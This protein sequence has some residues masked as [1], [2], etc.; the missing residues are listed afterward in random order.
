VLSCDL[1]NLIYD[2]YIYE[3]CNLLLGVL[4]C[5]ACQS[6][7]R[8]SSNGLFPTLLLLGHLA[9]HSLPHSDIE[10]GCEARA[11]TDLSAVLVEDEGR[12]CDEESDTA[13]EGASPV[14][15]ETG[16]HL[17]GEL[18]ASEVS[19][20]SYVKV[21]E[22]GVRGGKPLRRQSEGWC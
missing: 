20:S 3:S 2:I 18:C 10:A 21:G 19:M 4:T 15:T 16:E 7:R 14:D 6:A 8:P 5:S 17:A 11:T 1:T 22:L 12:G 13:D 9:L